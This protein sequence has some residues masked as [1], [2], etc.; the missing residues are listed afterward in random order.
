LTPT[1]VKSGASPTDV[2]RPIQA[3]DTRS[4]IALGLRR[5]RPRLSLGHQQELHGLIAAIATT[6]P[7]QAQ[8]LLSA[9]LDEAQ[10]RHRDLASIGLAAHDLFPTLQWLASLRVLRDLSRQGWRFALDD[11][12]VLLRAPGATP[13]G[14]TDPEREKEAL[15]R[16]FAFAREGQLNEPPTERFIRAMERRGVHRL[17]AD[18]SELADRLRVAGPE[19]IQPELEFIDNPRARDAGTGL[20]LQEVWRYAR[21]YWSIPYQSTPGRNMFFL[22][23][24]AAHEDRPLIGIAA[25]GNPVL[26]LAQR[27]DHAGWSADALR[28][29]LDRFSDSKRHEVVDRLCTVLDEGIE[30]TYADDLWPEGPPSDWRAEAERLARIQQES[31]DQ[32]L[33][34]LSTGDKPRDP[35]YQRIRAAHTAV[36]KGH[37]DQVDWLAI[38]RTHLYR[39]KRAGTLGDLLRARATLR[40]FGLPA[41]PDAV[42]A[43]LDAEEGRRA[44]EI[45][46]RRIKQGVIASSVMEIITCGAVPPYRDAL[47]GKLVALLML[48]RVVGDEYAAKYDG[49]VSLIA[50]AL[51]AKPVARPTRLALLTTSSLYAIGSSQ[52]NRLNVTIDDAGSVGYRRIGLTDSF[53]TVHFAPDTVA[54]LNQIA[55]LVDHDRRRIN[56][57]FGEGTSPKLRLI[58]SGLEGLGLDANVFLRHHSPRLL[59]AAALCS[60]IED[61]LLGLHDEPDYVLPAGEDSTA[62]LIERWRTRWLAPRLEREE[63][64]DRIAGSQREEFLLSRELASTTDLAGRRASSNPDVPDG[65]PRAAGQAD[66][67]VER[68]YRSTNSYADRLSQDELDAIHVDLGVDGYLLEEAGNNREIVVTGNPGDGKTHLIERLRS[69]LEAANAEIITD[70]NATSDEETLATWER[71]R[72]EGRPF[73]LAINE[74][75]LFVLQ[76]TA[77][78][79]GFTPVAEAL[80]QVREARFF[81]DAQIP[82]PPKDNVVTIDLSLRNLLAPSVVQRVIERLTNERFYEGLAESDPMLFNRQALQQPQAQERL[83][84]VLAVVAH[85]LGHVTMRQLVGFIAYLLSAGQ[86]AEDRLVAGQ[87]ATGI[88]YSNLAFE[89]GEGELFETVRRVFDPAAT[90]HPIWD[91]HIWS[92]PLESADWLGHPPAPILSFP[93]SERERAFRA[94]KRRF[95]FEHSQGGDLLA[96]EPSDEAEFQTILNEGGTGRTTLVRDLVLALNRFYEPDFSEQDQDRLLLWQ[97]HRYDVR[98]PSAFVSLR[99]LGYQQLRIEPLRYAEWVERWLPPEQQARRSFALVA[100]EATGKEIAVLEL[101]RQLYL[102]LLEAQHGLGRASWS[103]TATRRITRFIDLIDRELAVPTDVEDLRVRNF[104]TDLDERFVVQRHPARYQI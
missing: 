31:A 77:A 15:R 2:R 5:F 28:E 50:S 27:D 53:G 55:R 65:G 83:T 16:S 78:V 9:A 89:G 57:L 22:V 85:R 21:L 71:C 11:E 76:R 13:A 14:G 54:A 48:S 103:R 37:A 79:R 62:L 67:F 36:A 97:S 63:I 46:L 102:T 49:Q 58:R 73:V 32:R 88:P 86:S 17:L 34:Q 69:E 91:A 10:Q 30:E 47:G 66:T 45:A 90:T 70:A 25:L 84:S 72:K 52:Y 95:F 92:G 101:D 94:T 7:D 41:K 74:W 1:T 3:T 18:G 82:E 40:E 8:R 12:G 87:D 4:D 99:E 39:R 75:P 35:E 29:R 19:G 23:R 96:L 60:N 104:D 44:V 64:L 26:G 33:Q 24:D 51:A 20:R 59:Y 43:A 93:E 100:S 6:P 56:N 68:L 80:R 42:F 61:V 98:A 38:A 81:V